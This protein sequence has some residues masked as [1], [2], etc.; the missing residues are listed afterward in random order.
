MTLPMHPALPSNP[1]LWKLHAVHESALR[2]LDH[3]NNRKDF[4]E[5]EEFIYELEVKINEFHHTAD[6]LTRCFT[7]AYN[8]QPS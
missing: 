7:A 8:E 4:E 5:I 1:T 3:T 6:Y 2:W